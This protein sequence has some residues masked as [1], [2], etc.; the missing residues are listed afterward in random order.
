MIETL[1]EFMYE[2]MEIHCLSEALVQALHHC[3]DSEKDPGHLITLAET[4]EQR[5]KKM[6]RDMDA[7]TTELRR[8]AMLAETIV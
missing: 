4:T 8:Q 3:A 1:E 5:I 7:K 2:T 6:H